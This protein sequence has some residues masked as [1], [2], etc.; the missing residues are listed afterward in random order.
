MPYESFLS[1]ITVFC[2]NF[3]NLS[4]SYCYHKENNFTFSE[5][6]NVGLF[7]ETVEYMLQ[8]MKYGEYVNIFFLGRTLAELFLY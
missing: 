5:N 3:C 8:N 2:T 1:S 7:I 4:C 6:M